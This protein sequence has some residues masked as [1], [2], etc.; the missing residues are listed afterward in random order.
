MTGTFE[1][2]IA[3]STPVIIDFSAEW[4]VP[5][6]KI[7]PILSQLVDELDEEI[8]IIKIDI[9]KNPALRKKYNITAV[10]TLIAF[11]KGK[12]KWR[13]TGMITLVKAKQAIREIL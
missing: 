1:E 4:C 6:K 12:Q 10:P 2:L 13:H 9:D 8:S 5:C 7:T 3:S 11:K